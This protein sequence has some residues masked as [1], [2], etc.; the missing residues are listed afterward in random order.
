MTEVENEKSKSDDTLCTQ[1]KKLKNGYFSGG[2]IYGVRSE[3]TAGAEIKPLFST[4]R[5]KTIFN[6][7]S[8]GLGGTSL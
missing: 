6:E 4:K 8:T 3:N 7:I 1:R 2:Y 5:E